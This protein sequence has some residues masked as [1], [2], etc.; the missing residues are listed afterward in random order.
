MVYKDKNGRN[1]FMFNTIDEIEQYQWN[2]FK[3]ID[4]LFESR[5]QILQEKVQS[6]LTYVYRN[7][8][9]SIKNLA[10]ITTIKDR[11]EFIQSLQN[12]EFIKTKLQAK[13]SI[14]LREIYFLMNNHFF[15]FAAYTNIYCF[16]EESGR[17]IPI[18]F[19]D[20]FSEYKVANEPIDK[21]EVILSI[22]KKKIANLLH[23]KIE[24]GVLFAQKK[25]YTRD[26]LQEF[27]DKHMGIVR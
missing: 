11:K 22:Q 2:S 3:F 13:D 7:N 24:N 6:Y 16:L 26:D 19:E 9:D 18:R 14:L 15:G 25:Y 20:S 4:I 27:Y 17:L 1:I 21:V 8:L 5:K 10:S 12:K 23:E